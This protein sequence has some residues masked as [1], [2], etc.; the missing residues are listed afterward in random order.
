[1]TAPHVPRLARP[2]GEHLLV[3]PAGA[4][5]AHVSSGYALGGLHCH[6]HFLEGEVLGVA[7]IRVA[8]VVLTVFAAALVAATA[9]VAVTAALGLRGDET[10]DP[11][12][13]RAFTS[14]LAAA[15]SALTLLYM[16][17]ALVP[18]LAGDV[19]D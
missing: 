7:S 19:C 5:L 17:W 13:R 12:G 6:R 16:L 8:L 11:N 10:E 1:V 14:A 18:A 4:W 3:I 15:L 9:V 2:S